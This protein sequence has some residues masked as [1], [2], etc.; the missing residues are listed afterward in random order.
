MQLAAALDRVVRC[1]RSSQSL[2]G[3]DGG[4]ARQ[5]PLLVLRIDLALAQVDLVDV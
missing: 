2:L 4:V 3:L 1:V 5:F